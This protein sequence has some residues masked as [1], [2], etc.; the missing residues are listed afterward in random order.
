MN[1]KSKTLMLIA[2]AV[3]VTLFGTI[4]LTT[5]KS[6]ASS[7]IEDT[8]TTYTLTVSVGEG[9]TGNPTSGTNSYSEGQSVS[10]SYS[11]IS[12]YMNLVVTLD[13]Q[14]VDPTG[15]IT[16]DRNHTLNA[17]A[18]V[19]PVTFT[20]ADLT[21]TW[22]GTIGNF[23]I[24]F[25]VD[26]SGSIDYISGQCALIGTMTIDSSGEVTGDGIYTENFSN[27]GQASWTLQMSND[28]TTMSGTLGALIW[29][30]RSVSLTKQ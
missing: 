6:P 19:I 11:L 29:G 26:E 12:G 27:W 8:L 24:V 1:L 17:S 9:V 4:F 2:L 5:C 15:T 16:M 21:G 20:Q 22:T 23:N 10:Y 30:S 13:D 3:L 7:D 28:K 18:E 25:A 14:Q